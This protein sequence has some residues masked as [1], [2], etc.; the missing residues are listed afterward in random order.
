MI[1]LFAI[2]FLVLN[3]FVKFK[4]CFIIELSMLK[5]RRLVA[6][7]I[8]HFLASTHCYGYL[9]HSWKLLMFVEKIFIQPCLS[10]LHVFPYL[11]LGNINPSKWETKTLIPKPF[12]LIFLF[13]KATQKEY[14]PYVAQ[15]TFFN[16]K[17][18]RVLYLSFCCL[19]L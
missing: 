16:Y 13:S 10:N 12:D 5:L 17:L 18:F 2:F 8:H 15:E 19:N 11:C 6:N 9:F 1:G 14:I 3:T 7:C 4:G